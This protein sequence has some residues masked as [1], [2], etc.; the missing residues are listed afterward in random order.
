M[1]LE[2]AGDIVLQG[3]PWED[4]PPCETRGHV[5]GVTCLRCSGAGFL[6]SHETVVAY[7]MCGVPIHE[8]PMTPREKMAVVGAGFIRERLNEQSITRKIFPPTQ[9]P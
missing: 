1:T 4:C 3:K 9:V 7:E 2:E 8:K 6:L 5:N